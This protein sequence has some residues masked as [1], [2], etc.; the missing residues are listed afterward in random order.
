MDLREYKEEGVSSY[1]MTETEVQ[2]W[3]IPEDSRNSVVVVVV[4]VAQVM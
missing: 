3:I 1:W 4:A 2:A